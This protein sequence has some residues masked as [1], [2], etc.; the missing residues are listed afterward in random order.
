MKRKK[1]VIVSIIYNFIIVVFAVMYINCTDIELDIEGNRKADKLYGQIS[2]TIACIVEDNQEIIDTYKEGMDEGNNDLDIDELQKKLNGIEYIESALQPYDC[3]NISWFVVGTNGDVIYAH[4]Y[5]NYKIDNII[6]YYENANQLDY[7]Q[8]EL[9]KGGLAGYGNETVSYKNN[10]E[11]YYLTY[12]H[13]P[14]YA[15]GI[16]GIGPQTAYV[17]NNDYIKILV[18]TI[19]SIVFAVTVIFIINMTIDEQN[20]KNNLKKYDEKKYCV[21]DILA[22][23]CGDVFI[24]LSR[25]CKKVEYVSGNIWKMLGAD[26]ESS[27]KNDANLLEAKICGREL[28]NID[29]IRKIKTGEE[30]QSEEKYFNISDQQHHWYLKHIY[31]AEENFENRYLII[32]SDIT[33]EHDKNRHIRQALDIAKNAN[34]AKSKFLS[35]LSHDT[36]TPVNAISGMAVLL[37]RDACDKEM[38]VEYAERIS[39]SCRHLQNLVNNYLDINKIEAGKSTLNVAKFSI[40]KMLQDISQV[41]RVQI[42]NK[43]QMFIIETDNLCHNI[44]I[45]DKMRISQVIIN[46][47]SNAVKYTGINGTIRLYVREEIIK[48]AAKP[49]SK[50]VFT[51]TDNGSGMSKEYQ[52]IL[53]EPFSRE[54]SVYTAGVQGTGLGMAITKSLVELMGGTIKVSSELGKGSRFTVSIYLGTEDLHDIMKG[55]KAEDSTALNN[56]NCCDT[57]DKRALIA[58]DYDINAKILTEI[59]RM[60]DVSSDIAT[61]GREA[62]KLFEMSPSGYYDVILMDIQMPLMNGYDAARHI[63]GLERPDAKTVPIVAM[64]A[65]AFEKEIT[66][67]KNAGMDE[68]VAKPINIKSFRGKLRKLLSE[69][70]GT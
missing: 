58:E 44:F 13:N 6:T 49:G 50:L 67:A 36:K 51:V 47:L 68:Y 4:N 42:R 33:D 22:K 46:I 27:A 48:N 52:N 3:E 30:E 69:N 1:R 62:V 60:E 16:V 53:F 8:L 17:G 54:N 19:V 41:V 23:S 61:N 32:L 7:E 9:L 35:A 2:Q 65:N 28:L 38:V 20:S 70:E 37:A 5:E 25:D 26:Y 18:V 10:S 56:N 45:G 15:W 57:H 31:H 66:Q 21:F 43:K 14:G 11:T 55:N 59:L 63:R 12:V 39:Q 64:T 40:A 34:M 29:K 24:I